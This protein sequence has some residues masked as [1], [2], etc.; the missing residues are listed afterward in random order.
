[1][2]LQ[3]RVIAT[4]P[5]EVER[6]GA[7]LASE[8][9]DAHPAGHADAADVIVADVI[10]VVGPATIAPSAWDGHPAA[11]VSIA[12]AGATPPEAA[13]LEAPRVTLPSDATARELALAC[14]LLAE[15]VRLRRLVDARGA[16]DHPSIDQ[17]L[18]D[19]LTGLPNRRAWQREF[20]ARL[21]AAGDGGGVC[22]AIIDLDHFKQ[23]NT[24]WGHGMGDR[25]LVVMAEALRHGLRPG[26]FVA[27]LGGDEF[28]L[29]LSGLNEQDA[30]AVVD[31]VVSCSAGFKVTRPGERATADALFAAADAALRQAKYAGRDVTMPATP[32]N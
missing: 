30:G 31:R 26:D 18:T 20:D 29:L 6:V 15:I 19:E 27:R 16:A 10:V 17:S 21:R 2:S 9:L 13:D 25:L 7:M 11:Q 8:G 22:L 14:R 24:G 28:V 32:W 1:M 12:P 4:D 23:V 5:R 3:V